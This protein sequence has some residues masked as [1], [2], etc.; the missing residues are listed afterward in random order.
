MLEAIISHY[1]ST[2]VANMQSGISHRYRVPGL[3]FFECK[4]KILLKELLLKEELLAKLKGG[5]FQSEKAIAKV[6]F[7]IKA[8]NNV[9]DMMVQEN[10]RKEEFKI[11]KH[12]L[13]KNL[14]KPESD[15]GR[16]PE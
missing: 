8:I 15:S 9:L 12:E 1:Y 2:L 16:N 11:L 10:E 13:I 7:S 4:P 6:E 3:G 5:D 14:E